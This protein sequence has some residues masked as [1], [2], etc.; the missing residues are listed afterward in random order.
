MKSSLSLA[1][2]ALMQG[3]RA[4]KSVAS[5]DVFG[6]NGTNYKNDNPTVDMSQIEINITELSKIKDAESCIPGT[7]VTAHA[8]GTL[9]DGRVVTDTKQEHDGLPISFPIGT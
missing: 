1:V 8:K 9:I 4:I 6:P 2:V 7:W 3:T 5:P